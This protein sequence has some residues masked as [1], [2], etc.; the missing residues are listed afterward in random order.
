MGTEG[1][2]QRMWTGPGH[3]AS[4]IEPVILQIP[5]AGPR[6]CGPALPTSEHSSPKKPEFADLWC[7]FRGGSRMLAQ[8]LIVLSLLT[9]SR[10]LFKF[11]LC[12]KSWG[13]VLGKGVQPL[14]S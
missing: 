3:R 7:L 14:L 12:S 10:I 8:T 2:A 5:S 11:L 1:K 6:G 13:A 9:F 4:V